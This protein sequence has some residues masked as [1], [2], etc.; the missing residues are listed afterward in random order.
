MC[1]AESRG[2]SSIIWKVAYFGGTVAS[3]YA[4]ADTSFPEF[5][6]CFVKHIIKVILLLWQ[7][8]YT[9]DNNRHV[10]LFQQGC[11]LCGIVAPQNN[12]LQL[13][14]ICEGQHPPDIDLAIDAKYHGTLA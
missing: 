4:K 2:H 13:H 5:C 3:R 7:R 8:K 9:R 1:Q 11:N 6:R 12:R 14:F 10:L